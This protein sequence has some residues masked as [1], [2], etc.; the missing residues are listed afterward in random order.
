MQKKKKKKKNDIAKVDQH[1]CHYMASLGHI[2]LMM[3]KG[4]GQVLFF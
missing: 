4:I 3:Q 1:M 2:E